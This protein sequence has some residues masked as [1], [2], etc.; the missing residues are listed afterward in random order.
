LPFGSYFVVV[1]LG[2]LRVCEIE[3]ILDVDGAEKKR[4]GSR[5]SAFGAAARIAECDEDV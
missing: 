1:F 5:S 4:R 2:V 3:V